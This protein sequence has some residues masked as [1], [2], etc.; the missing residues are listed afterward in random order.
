MIWY[1]P[2]SLCCLL[3]VMC[4]FCLSYPLLSL[5]AFDSRIYFFKPPSNVG[6]TVSRSPVVAPTIV[7]RSSIVRRMPGDGIYVATVSIK[8]FVLEA[9]CRFQ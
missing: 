3:T 5:Q 2:V 4:V 6:C 7:V 8:L 1:L 9:D